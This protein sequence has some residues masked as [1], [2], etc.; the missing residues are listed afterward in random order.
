SD[1]CSSDLL[2]ERLPRCRL[3]ERLAGRDRPAG[4]RPA[5]LLRLSPAQGQQHS[6]VRVGDDCTGCQYPFHTSS[7]YGRAAPLFRVSERGLGGGVHLRG[8]PPS[9]TPPAVSGARREEQSPCSTSPPPFS[10]P[11]LGSCRW[12]STSSPM[13]AG[14]LA[15]RSFA[16]SSGP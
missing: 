10:P 11:V 6:P 16:P 3:G 13:T 14:C 2:P 12:R 15:S 5:P 4:H 9:A 1:V 8:E 7:P